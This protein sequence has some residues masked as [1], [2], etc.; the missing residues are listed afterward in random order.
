MRTSKLRVALAVLVGAA[1]L[2]LSACGGGDSSSAAGSRTPTPPT[3]RAPE[4]KVLMPYKVPEELLDQFTTRPGSTSS[5][6]PAPGTGSRRSSSSRNQ[7]GTYIA[8]VTEF[9][10]SFTGQFGGNGW[11][12]PLQD[13]LDPK[14]LDDLGNTKA[15]F[16]S[17]GNLYAACYSNDF[18]IS[19]YNSALFKQAGLDGFPETFDDLD[20]A[21]DTLKAQGVADS[22][23]TMPMAAT[24]GSVTPWYLLTLAMGGQLFD[25]NDPPVFNEPNSAG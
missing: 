4:I 15:S 6:T 19:M 9:D 18:R 12:E 23:M 7:A 1:A 21:L 25:E 5:T 11:Y 20:Q 14:L 22:P 13:V 10:W 17:D 3:S 24:E 2:A 8:D 16:T